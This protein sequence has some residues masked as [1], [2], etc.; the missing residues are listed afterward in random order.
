GDQVTLITMA[1]DDANS[2]DEFDPLPDQTVSA[3]TVDDDTA[4]IS[5]N[6]ITA[7]TSEAGGTATFT[8][9]LDSEPTAD[10][11]IGV[12][13]DDPTEG[14]VTSPTPLIFTPTGGGTPW[15]TPQTVTV[16]GQDDALFDGDI[17]YNIVTSP[18]VSG[19]ANYSGRDAADVSLVNT[20]DETD[21]LSL[22]DLGDAAPADDDGL[23]RNIDAV[24]TAEQEPTR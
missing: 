11:S 24:P 23:E 1:I 21:T 4:G 15:N 10:V 17:A 19:D 9:Q 5:V 2:D 14:L 16:T 6:V 8:V 20:D 7:T 18:A 13:S 3:T 22:T 12:S